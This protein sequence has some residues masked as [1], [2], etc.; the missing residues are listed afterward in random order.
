MK[1]L[2]CALYITYSAVIVFCSTLF[3]CVSY[4]DQSQSCNKYRATKQAQEAAGDRQ[5]VVTTTVDQPEKTAAQQKVSAD[6][7]AVGDV[8][9]CF[10]SKYKE[11]EP[12]LG[13]VTEKTEKKVLLAWMTGDYDEP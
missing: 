1:L 10:L 4:T 7:V 3:I 8:V 13:I 11:E 12:Q 6:Q 2:V 5:R 9:A